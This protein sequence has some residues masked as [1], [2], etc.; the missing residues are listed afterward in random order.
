M[1]YSAKLIAA[2]VLSFAGTAHAGYAQAVP[3][4]GWSPGSY[5]P[6]ANDATYGRVIYAPNGPTTNVG[7]QAV[8]MPAAYRLAANA[9]RI[10]AGVIFAHPYVRLAAGIASWLSI[11]KFVYDE[12]RKV[13][14]QTIE[15]SEVISPG[16]EYS[17]ANS[18]ARYPTA[19]EAR[20]AQIN[21]LNTQFGQSRFSVGQVISDVHFQIHDSVT[22]QT[23]GH[24]L[25]RYEIPCPVNT[26]KTPAGCVYDAAKIIDVNKE[27]FEQQL[28]STPMPDTVPLELPKPTPLPV[29]LPWINPSPG[30]NPQHQPLFV[31]TGDPVPNPNF[32][33]NSPVSPSNLPYMQPGVRV[34]PS[35]TPTEPWRVDIQPVNRPQENPNP[36]PEPGTEPGTDPADKPKPEEQQSLCEK[37]P[38]IVACAKL[39]EPGQATPVPNETKTLTIAP[40]NGFGPSGG[41]CP[42]PRTVEV[43]GLTLS[44]PFD[45]LCDFATGL[46]PVIV[47]LAWLT[48]A[49][50]FMGIGRRS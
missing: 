40:E 35:P 32:N 13:W 39:G 5:A 26:V 21:S 3:P 25:S 46:K 11:G 17:N 38:D 49:F 47:G 44:M 29:E 23:S 31:P 1:D 14:T 36:N 4:S 30:P 50:T 33:P 15:S 45:L 37:H 2:L 42:P 43:A 48:A 12:S 27:Q 6:S 7:G 41:S 24:S 8:R 18:N 28:P 22:N 9:P 20:Q 19:N 10:A 16:Y 34:V